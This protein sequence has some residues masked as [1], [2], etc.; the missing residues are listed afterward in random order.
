MTYEQRRYGFDSLRLLAAGAAGTARD[1]ALGRSP[2]TVSGDVPC[3]EGTIHH[4]V[5]EL[6]DTGQTDTLE[7]YDVTN[8][9]QVA[10]STPVLIVR[11]WGAATTGSYTIQVHRRFSNGMVVRSPSGAGEL[12]TANVCVMYAASSTQKPGWV[13][14]R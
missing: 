1:W 12:N 3:L 6:P 7:L 4:I 10:T 13:Y 9:N 11:P 8:V 5:V 2:N 14:M